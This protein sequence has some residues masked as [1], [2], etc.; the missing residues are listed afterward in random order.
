MENNLSKSI[1]AAT[2]S[3]LTD[4]TKDIVEAA[5]DSLTDDGMMKDIPVVNTIHSLYK[6]GTSIRERIFINMILK[7]LVEL[8]DIP[9]EK[10][11]EFADRLQEGSYRDKAGEKIIVILDKLDDSDKASMIGKLFRACIQ[12]KFIFEDFLRLSHI[13]NNS[14]LDDLRVL[15]SGFQVDG[16]V[17]TYSLSDSD[18]SK[19]Y[20]VGLA[21]AVIVPDA[22]SIARRE[23]YRETNK[24]IDYK[25]AYKLNNDAY[26]ITRELFDFAWIEEVYGIYKGRK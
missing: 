6:I 17:A 21:S 15:K 24:P 18:L 20:R 26:I 9:L 11:K 22:S 14:F 2:A 13:V 1:I 4:I 16:R 7:F 12:G 8:K 3:N 10:R 5:F 23:R 25:T 19:L